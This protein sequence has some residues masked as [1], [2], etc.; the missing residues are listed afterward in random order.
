[1]IAFAIACGVVA[2]LCTILWSKLS[3][4]KKQ[5]KKQYSQGNG[6]PVGPTENIWRIMHDKNGSVII[7]NTLV[8]RSKK[9]IQ[10]TVVKKA[11]NS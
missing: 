3:G 2:I 10:A 7:A 8:L 5:F 11:W 4:K 1:M 6:R 9:P